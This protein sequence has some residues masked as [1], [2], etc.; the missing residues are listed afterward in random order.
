MNAELILG[1][2][3]LSNT[4][5]FGH[6]VNFERMEDKLAEDSKGMTVLEYIL[7]GEGNKKIKSTESARAEC[8]DRNKETFLLWPPPSGDFQKQASG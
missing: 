7:D 1:W 4:T 3:R 5:L 6:L 2:L 8:T